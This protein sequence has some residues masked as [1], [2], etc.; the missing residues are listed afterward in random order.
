M[1]TK[2]LTNS[3]LS[4]AATAQVRALASAA[5]AAGHEATFRACDLALQGDRHAA[6]LVAQLL[7]R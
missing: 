5:K 4:G 6:R 2:N 3:I 1:N 7:S